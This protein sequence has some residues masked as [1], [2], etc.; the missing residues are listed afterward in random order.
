MGLCSFFLISTFFF[1][2]KTRFSSFLAFFW[3]LLGDIFLLFFFITNFIIS[4]Y[5]SILIFF[6]LYL[7]FLFLVFSIFCKSAIFPF[8]AWLYYAM[9][10]PTPVSAFLH[11]A[12]MITAGVYFFFIFPLY[13]ISNFFLF[14]SL[15]STLFFSLSAYVYFDMKKVIASSTGS[16]IGYIFF[17][18]SINLGLCGIKLFTFHA[19]FK[20]LLFFL[21]GFIVSKFLNSQ[22]LR[23]IKINYFLFLLSS[24]CFFSLLGLFFFWSGLI[25]EIFISH[26]IV[27]VINLVLFLILFIFSLIYSYKFFYTAFFSFFYFDIKLINLFF[28]LVFFFTLFVIYIINFLFYF[29]LPGFFYIYLIS[30]FFL[31]LSYEKII[32]F[33][34]DYIY[35]FILNFLWTLIKKLSY[36][37]Y[38]IYYVYFIFF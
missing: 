30:L 15:F 18:L 23:F 28:F 22:D 21:A 29:S 4:F 32:L 35:N 36:F 17:F 11:A 24:L 7:N 1:R 33:F 8:H 5:L 19:V 10:G 31:F 3:N 38:T 37:F 13:K 2:F 20:S 14:L 12:S 27:N 25:K 6:F 26:V 34:L 16:Q 9:E